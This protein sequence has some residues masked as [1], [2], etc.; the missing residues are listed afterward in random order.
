VL[1]PT[2][3]EGEEI[4]F[5]LPDPDHVNVSVRLWS[6]L[7]L[8][9]GLD[10]VWV[11]GGWELRMPLPEV[12]CLEYM[13]ELSGGPDPRLELDP[14]NPEQVDGPFGVHSWLVLPSYVAPAWLD[15]EAVPGSRTSLKVTRTPVGTI[16]VTVW[17]PDGPGDGDLP[18]LIAHDGPEMDELGELTRYVAALIGDGRLQPVRVALM[19]PGPR[20][21]RYAANPAYAAALIDWVLPR[22][23]RVFPTRGLPAL[24]GQSLGGVAALH[25]AWTSPGAFGGLFLQSGSYFTAELD[26]QESGYRHWAPV[27]EFVAMVHAAN[28]AAPGAPRMALTCGTAE[29]NYANNRLMAD[30]L[31][32]IGVRVS[33][34]ETR[35]GHTWTCWR[36]T[37]DPYLTDLL[38][39]VF[40]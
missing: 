3:V 21:E 28:Q 11:P 40:G 8:G 23:R 27:T 7:D 13:F 29:E 16:D 25:A 18:L 38:T 17:T 31:A 5:R 6:N 10:L 33:W 14:G 19:T 12:D 35:Q 20:D 32:A 1:A 37:L 4:A 39:E 30:H 9:A 34:G 24:S 36:D 2:A 22:L 15:L 26:G